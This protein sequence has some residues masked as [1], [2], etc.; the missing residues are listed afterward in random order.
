[1]EKPFTRDD[2]GNRVFVVGQ[3]SWADM[4]GGG[5]VATLPLYQSSDGKKSR[6]PIIVME[7]SDKAFIPG[8]AARPNEPLYAAAANRKASD[9]DFD[10]VA[11]TCKFK[12]VFGLMIRCVAPK[13]KSKKTHSAQ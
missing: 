1:M 9:P 2:L 4:E 7:P 6:Y 10:Y 11:Y 8:G 3:E 12:G 13:A 5:K